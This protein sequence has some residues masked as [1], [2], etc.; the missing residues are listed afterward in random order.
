MLDF[1]LPIFPYG[2]TALSVTTS[3]LVGVWVVVFFNLRFGWTLSGLVV[4]GYLVPLLII[5]P[6]AVVVILF[7]AILTYRIVRYVS[8]P[9]KLRPW[10][11]FFGR[12]R[13]FAIVVVS[14]IVRCAVDGWGLPWLTS[15]SKE[16][17]GIQFHWYDE[18]HSYGLII[19]SLVANC[20]WKSGFSRGMIPL[21]VNILI[22]YVI[23]RYGLSEWTNYSTGDLQFMYEDIASSLL[24]SPK[25]YIILLSTAFLASWV[26]LR[27]GWEFN[28]ILIPALLALQWHSPFKILVTFVEL[29][30]ILIVAVPVLS[31]PIFKRIT[32]EGGR[33]ILLFFTLAFGYRLL[34]GHL[35]PEVLPEYKVT[36]LYG[37]GYLLST[38]LAIKIHDHKLWIRIPQVSL[39]TSIVGAV[40]GSLL[41]LFM[42][43]FP[44]NYHH[45]T[46]AADLSA[47]SIQRIEAPVAEHLLKFKPTLYRNTRNYYLPSTHEQMT[48]EVVI[49]SLISMSQTDKLTLTREFQKNLSEIHYR[50]QLVEK[51]YLI[52]SETDQRGRG[53]Y[54]LDLKQ[55][56][57]VVITVPQPLKLWGN[58]ES[59]LCL[60]KKLNCSALV[61]S[62]QSSVKYMGHPESFTSI[63]HRTFASGR[64][65][66][67]RGTPLSSS[68]HSP[69][70][71][72]TVWLSHGIAKPLALPQ[73]RSLV[74]TLNVQWGASPDKNRMRDSQT[75]AY[76]ELVLSHEDRGRLLAMLFAEGDNLTSQAVLRFEE[77]SLHGEVRNIRDHI[78]ERE[79]NQFQH[80]KPEELLFLD[81][82]VLTPMIQF[83]LTGQE[84]TDCPQ[85]QRDQLNSTSSAASIF[86]YQWSLINDDTDRYM[87]LHEKDKKVKR[88]WGALWLRLGNAR[89]Y[90]IEVPR[91][92]L[93]LNTIETGAH[94]FD[95]LQA[96]ALIVAAA[97]P[98]ANS[99]GSADV[100][101]GIHENLFNLIR[102]VLIRESLSQSWR[103][104]QVRAA[105]DLTT[106]LLLAPE[107]PTINTELWF[108]D[109]H[110]TLK[111]QGLSYEYTSGKS[112]QAS[113]TYSDQF[114]QR[115]LRLGVNV[116]GL[117]MWISPHVRKSYRAQDQDDLAEAMFEAVGIS[118]ATV[119]IKQYLVDHSIDLK[120]SHL[121][122][123]DRE[124]LTAF[125]QRHDVVRLRQ[126]LLRH[127][128]TKWERVI[129]ANSKMAFLVG[130][131]HKEV[132]LVRLSEWTG[133]LPHYISYVS[134]TSIKLYLQSLF[135]WWELEREFN[136]DEE[137]L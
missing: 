24:A 80:P 60:F 69:N 131:S 59:G 92:G 114:S 127:P 74:R 102:Q 56:S 99:D 96:R 93:E 5:K 22:T 136:S 1:T 108:D 9:G 77:G 44:M 119:D 122:S 83:V 115:A 64:T 71:T 32:M 103:Q 50:I 129:D 62:G 106:N 104:V 109:L 82:E 63:F 52:L 86:N 101:Y 53:I 116:Q 57:G 13:F 95:Q 38:L 54:V 26:N 89:S 73:L 30:A 90:G 28:G 111:K 41:G 37:F 27:Y 124:L 130:L 34:L 33:K 118:T 40:A 110:S 23:V 42:T 6:H 134:E 105:E 55:P 67:V 14:V 128:E 35:I 72:S 113:Y 49:R 47:V 2:S 94:L 19:V 117:M 97:H 137:S 15:V 16:Y 39:Q 48:F 31:L 87:V 125:L 17:F 45:N 4:P 43:H 121:D 21:S 7:E 98:Q 81:R 126:L 10:T 84:W 123:T 88:G 120:P 51:R 25:A 68:Q 85:Q 29:F 100:I 65:L 46:I 79:T 135:P 58:L 76:A 112:T 11:S 61:I 66:E 18:L 3:V 133:H 75:F 70:D 91:P 12:D 132:W 8:S 20:F 107:D 36:D 78:V